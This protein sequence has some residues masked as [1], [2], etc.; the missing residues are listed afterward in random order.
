MNFILDFLHSQTFA[1][2]DLLVIGFLAI[3]EGALSIDNALVLGLLAKRLRREEQ[4]QALNIGM[5][6]GATT[7]TINKG[8]I[9][10]GSVIILALAIYLLLEPD[11]VRRVLTGSSRSP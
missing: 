9:I 3:L 4:G 1:W 7:A 5:F 2:A 6:S 8:L 10:S 11:K